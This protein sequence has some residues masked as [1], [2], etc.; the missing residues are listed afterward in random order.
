ML[1]HPWQ[2]S[3]RDYA[4]QEGVP[5]APYGMVRV[6]ADVAGAVVDEAIRAGDTD[7]CTVEH[8]TISSSE[9]AHCWMRVV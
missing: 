2:R 7:N 8:A 5:D 1:S 3:T 4:L 6:V 9:Q